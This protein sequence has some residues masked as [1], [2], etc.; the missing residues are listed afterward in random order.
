[1][2]NFLC[3]PLQCI[4]SCSIL[5]VR[6]PQAAPVH[7]TVRKFSNCIICDTK[8]CRPSSFARRSALLLPLYFIP[9]SFFPDSSYFHRHFFLICYM[10][11]HAFLLVFFLFS[12]CLGFLLRLWLQKTLASWSGF[13]IDWNTKRPTACCQI[14]ISFELR[15]AHELSVLNLQTSSNITGGQSS[16]LLPISRAVEWTFRST[17]AEFSDLR[18]WHGVLDDVLNA[19]VLGPAADADAGLQIVILEPDAGRWNGGRSR[20]R[21]REHARNASPPSSATSSSITP[22]GGHDHVECE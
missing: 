11:W 16:G 4:N 20:R 19:T 5:Q 14:G 10:K 21:R 9:R 22:L 13:S 3:F 1:M 6:R 18:K 15:T 2:L 12:L 7:Q 17:A 8:N